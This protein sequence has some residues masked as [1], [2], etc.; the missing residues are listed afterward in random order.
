MLIYTS[1]Q[2]STNHGFGAAGDQ[3]LRPARPYPVGRQ[4][5]GL[6]SGTAKPVDGHSRD[7]IRQPRPQRRLPRH[8]A[9]RL[10]FGHGTTQDDIVDTILRLWIPLQQ[11]DD[12][13]RRQIVRPRIPQRPLRRLA[14][15]GAQTIDNHGFVHMSSVQS[16]VFSRQ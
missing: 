11:R 4:R 8:V 16:S 15:C 2:C 12:H 6:Q 10:A 3:Q 14:Y 5:D 13:L 1:G 9:A 7:E